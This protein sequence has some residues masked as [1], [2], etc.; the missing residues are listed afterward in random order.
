M[1]QD[2][3]G[4]YKRSKFLAEKAALETARE[5]SFPV[6]IVN[7]TAPIGDHDWKPTPTGKIVV[8]FLRR[9]MPAYVDTGLNVVDVRD[10]AGGSFI[11]MRTGPSGGTIILGGENLTLQQIFEKLERISG[12]KRQRSGFHMPLPT[13]RVVSH[14]VGKCSG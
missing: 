6:V 11:G 13:R 8:D 10:V 1:K 7:P 2:M 3:Q 4:A 5:R 12:L 14:D 9:K